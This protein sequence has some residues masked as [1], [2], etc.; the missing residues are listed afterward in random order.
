MIYDHVEGSQ[1]HDKP[2]QQSTL[3][4]HQLLGKVHVGKIYQRIFRTIELIPLH[5]VIRK[6]VS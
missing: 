3:I 1:V 6:A 2:V 5:F 4:F